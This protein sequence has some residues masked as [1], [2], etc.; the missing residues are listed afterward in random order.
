M[1]NADRLHMHTSS[2]Q[3]YVR[4]LSTSW[5]NLAQITQWKSPKQRKTGFEYLKV[6]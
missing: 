2:F 3:F 6:S 4:F 1:G 5:K